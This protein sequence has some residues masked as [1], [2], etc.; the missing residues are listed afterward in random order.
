MIGFS[1]RRAAFGAVGCL[2][3]A[4]CGA[5]QQSTAGTGGA[6][7]AAP[8]TV[9]SSTANAAATSRP[10][11]AAGGG[12]LTACGLI[13]EQEATTAIGSTV[14][15]G[16]AGGTAA[17]SECIYGDGALIVSMRTD[18]KAFYETSQTA[19]RARGATNVPGLGDGAFEAGA[20]Q[21][22]TLLFLKGTT[23]VSIILSA[24][25]AKDAAV[26]VAKIAAAKL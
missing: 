18:S 14:G 22:T 26:T 9:P 3:L 17:L 13:T 1:T 12:G 7:P 24:P 19:A 16:T 25:G 21:V 5:A 2:L 23:I 4:G 20:G 8:A 11:A 10:A 6:R 15:P